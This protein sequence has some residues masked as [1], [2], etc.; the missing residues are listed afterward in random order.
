MGHERRLTH[1]YR[2]AWLAGPLTVLALM[3]AVLVA[4]ASPAPDDP[5]EGVRFEL[6][7]SVQGRPIRGIRF[8]TGP[9]RLALM[10]SIHGGWERNTERLVSMALDH[11]QAN[12]SEVPPRLSVF[13]VP[14]TNPDGL[15]LGSG[16]EDAWNARGI[17]LNRNF[18]TPNWSP[19]PHGR[20]GGR[21]GPTGTRKGAGG[22]APFSEPETQAIRDFILGQ[23]IGVVVSYHSGIVSVTAKDGGGIG[24]PLARQM[25]GV[26]GY[27]YIETWTEYELTGQF[28]DWLD[29]VGVR[30]IEVELPDQQ[31]LDWEKNLVA[32][33]VLMQTLASE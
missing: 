25:A 5:A 10:G 12:R 7:P 27:P 18:D 21:Y 30:G 14:T 6:G 28:M 19:D 23:G 17:D 4:A 1:A 3:L 8:G 9:V 2:W 31:T 29:A 15:A 24:S 33:Q 13:F 32:V 26:T 20:A 11:V 16:P 22:P